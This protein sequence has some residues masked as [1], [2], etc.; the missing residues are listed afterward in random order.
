[1]NIQ[2]HPAEFEAVQTGLSRARHL[3]CCNKQQEHVVTHSKSKLARME[4][5][6]EH[7]RPR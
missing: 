1:M 6:C 4:S 2:N 5:R 7:S 3:S